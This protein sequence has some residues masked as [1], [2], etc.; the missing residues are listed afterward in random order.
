MG[1]TRP[2]VA[3]SPAMPARI[4]PRQPL[5]QHHPRQRP[6]VQPHLDQVTAITVAALRMYGD[7]ICGKDH[8]PQVPFGFLCG[9]IFGRASGG[10]QLGRVKP[11]QA[12]TL[13][14]PP[15]RTRASR[16]RHR[17]Q[18]GCGNWHRGREPHAE[19]HR[20]RR[21]PPETTAQGPQRQMRCGRA[22]CARCVARFRRGRIALPC[23]ACSDPRA[24]S[25]VPLP[26][27]SRPA[28]GC[29]STVP[30]MQ[31]KVP[32]LDRRNGWRVQ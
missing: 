25:R 29:R 2:C 7:G 5:L 11:R 30:L 4:G 20:S 23:P 12:G 22:T 9:K 14:R 18:T 17:P 1:I 13:R 6:T 19:P 16:C 26:G 10:K 31:I 3:P 15:P 28:T 24:G 21:S 32:E 8:Q 27:A